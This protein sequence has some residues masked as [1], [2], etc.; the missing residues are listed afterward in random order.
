MNCD[1]THPLLHAYHDGE[2]DLM[3]SLA[4]EQHL[5]TCAGCDASRRS[6][7]SLRLALRQHDLAYRAPKSLRSRLLRTVRESNGDTTTRDH[8]QTLWR[9][10]AVGATA[11]A[12][13]T[14]LLRPAGISG[15]DQLVNEAIAGHVRSLMA[16]HLTD[17][18]SSDQHTV[19]PWFN[20]KLDFAPPVEDFAGQGFPLVGG[21]LDYLDGHQVA[22]L[23]YH[24]NKHFINVF[25]WPAGN[26]K[27][28]QK[29]ESRRGYTVI[30][31]ASKDLH[32]CVVSDLNEKKMGDFDG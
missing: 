18:A 3:H 20:G 28:G 29:I 10:L 27:G 4:V 17:V 7:Q 26:E 12:V 31:R 21:R 6:L 25:I 16:E 11:F 19:K 30:E 24:H 1:E 5:K 14:L 8:W 32:F 2:L 22:A 23:V 13:L 15:H 9:W